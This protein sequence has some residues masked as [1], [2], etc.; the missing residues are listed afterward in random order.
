MLRRQQSAA[1]LSAN[2]SRFGVL[3]NAKNQLL[4]GESLFFKKNLFGTF[5][6]ICRHYDPSTPTLGWVKCGKGEKNST[7]ITRPAL[8]SCC[9]CSPANGPVTE[10]CKEKQ[11][12]KYWNTIYE[13]LRKKAVSVNRRA[14]THT[15][16][17][18]CVCAR[19]DSVS[20]A[21]G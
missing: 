19:L 18:V 21:R 7:S 6:N 5:M 11:S 3:M 15:H 13:S 1:V 2:G 12:G 17:E 4:W 16:A 20:A 8:G 10:I 9:F 14:H